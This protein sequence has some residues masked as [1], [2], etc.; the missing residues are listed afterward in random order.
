MT[1]A[2]DE[3]AAE[4]APRARRS[5]AAPRT[6]DRVYH[7]ADLANLDSIKEH[8]LLSTSRLLDMAGLRGAER[9]RVEREHRPRYVVLPNGVAIRDQR[10]MPPGALARC[11]RGVTVPE[12]Y[13]LLNSK[14]FFWCDDD[15]LERLR[16]T[17]RNIPSVVL[18]IDAARL[19][20]RYAGRAAVTP[21]NTG[22]AFRRPAPRGRATLVPYAT[23][24]ESGWASETAALGTGPRSRSHPPAE[25]VIDG[26]VPDLMDYVIQERPFSP[27]P[28]AER[29]FLGE[30]SAS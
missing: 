15:R 6:L 16:N 4:A 25:L 24:L 19:L 21:F 10:P 30:G 18:V 14:V 12:W 22:A 2:V 11:L 20:A 9:D 29:R 28:P 26:A 7:L 27:A 13:E 1:G 8:G 5:G 23:W 3:P 17:Y